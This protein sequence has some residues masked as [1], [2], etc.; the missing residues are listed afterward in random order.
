MVHA[1]QSL[2]VPF[3]AFAALLATGASACRSSTP[4]SEQP[5]VIPYTGVAEAGCARCRFQADEPGCD[6]AIRV[7]GRTWLVT[8]T[9]IDDHGDAHAADGFCNATR[10]ARVAGRFEGGRFV[11]DE[12]EL[13]PATP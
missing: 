5:V 9:E 12:F 1:S 4:L 3:L 7:E 13:L 2:T 11:A 10:Q 6:L 8:G